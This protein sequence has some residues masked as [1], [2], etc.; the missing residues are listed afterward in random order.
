MGISDDKI[1][2][3]SIEALGEKFKDLTCTICAELVEKPQQCKN[4]LHLYCKRC[5]EEWKKK[6]NKCPF[7]CRES[8]LE[9]E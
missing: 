5:I 8:A 6:Q 1:D 3:K 4:C 2:K 9:L 7:K